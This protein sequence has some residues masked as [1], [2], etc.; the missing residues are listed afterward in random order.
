METLLKSQ[1]LKRL[2]F[3]ERKGDEIENFFANDDLDY[4]Y[5]FEKNEF[6]SDQ[7]QWTMSSVLKRFLYRIIRTFKFQCR[8]RMKDCPLCTSNNTNFIFVGFTV[9]IPKN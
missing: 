7:L 6:I 1:Y 9:Q 5:L 8:I 3:Y 2:E 4:L